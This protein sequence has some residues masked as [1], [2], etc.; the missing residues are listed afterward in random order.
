MRP[1]IDIGACEVRTYHL[2]CAI[3]CPDSKARFAR[4]LIYGCGALFTLLPLH[5][6]TEVHRFMDGPRLRTILVHQVTEGLSVGV[7]TSMLPEGSKV[8]AWI[9]VVL[10]TRLGHLIR[11]ARY[12]R[13]GSVVSLSNQLC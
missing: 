4:T 1:T 3:P 9:A 2:S 5:R 8:Y 6:K 10:T 7:E 11:W 12:C 13:D